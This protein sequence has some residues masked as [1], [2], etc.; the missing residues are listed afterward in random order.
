MITGFNTD[1]EHDG[2]VYHVQTEDKGLDSPLILSLVYTGGAILASKRSPYQDLIAEGFDEA[3]LADRLK[4]Q[5]RLIC[6]AIRAGRVEELK[7]MNTREPVTEK[8]GESEFIQT[9]SEQLPP[10]PPDFGQ[11]TLDP[12]R[13][14]GSYSLSYIDRTRAESAPP[15]SPELQNVTE[16]E[17]EEGLRVSLIEEQEFRSGETLNLGVLVTHKTAREEKPVAGVAV[18]VKVLG[19]TFRPLIVSLKTQKDGVAMVSTTI[20]NF[21]SGRAAILVRA[22]RGGESV[23]IRRVVLPAK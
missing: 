15:A 12:G 5:H 1:V 6:A 10:P 16:A 4:R 2:V 13:A 9:P 22:V 8:A 7:R 18:S 20:P 23:E 3:V 14:V 11:L 17:L 21:S 19:T